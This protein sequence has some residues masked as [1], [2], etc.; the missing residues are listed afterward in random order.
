VVGPI[1]N[2]SAKRINAEYEE[3]H[4]AKTVTQIR[5]FIG[6]L[7]S[8]QQEH[9]SLRIRMCIFFFPVLLKQVH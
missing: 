7:G 1:L 8:I 3:R 2:K 6:K 5:E 4:S 9:Q